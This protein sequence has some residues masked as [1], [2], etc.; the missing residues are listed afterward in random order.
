MFERRQYIFVGL[1]EVYIHYEYIV[2]KY[3]T[4]IL[5]AGSNVHQFEKTSS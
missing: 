1:D 2:Y 3:T 5:R 4:R